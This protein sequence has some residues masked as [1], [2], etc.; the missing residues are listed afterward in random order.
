M[1]LL[2]I[3]CYL[4]WNATD[5][6]LKQGAETHIFLWWKNSVNWCL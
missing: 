2:Y 5:H 3:A 4:D 6:L 1:H